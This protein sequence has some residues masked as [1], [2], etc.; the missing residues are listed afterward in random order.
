MPGSAMKRRILFLISSFAQG[1]AQRHLLELIRLLDPAAFEIAICTLNDVNHFGGDLPAGQPAY[2]LRSPVFWSPLAFA[3]LAGAIRSFRPD[4]LHCYL[5]DGNLWGRLASRLSRPG[6]VLTSVHLDEMSPLYQ[7]WERRLNRWSD[8]I[9]AHS[10]SIER[11]LVGDLAVPA[12][13]VSVIANGVDVDRFA[14]VTDASRR[15]ARDARGLGADAFVALMPARVAWQKNQDLVLEAMGAL[16]ARG[17][18]PAGFRLLLAGGI[19][20]QVL[21]RKV[22]GLIASHG[23]AQNVQRLGP[24]KDMPAVLHAADVVLLPSRT[25]ASPIAALEG[26]STAVPVVI[27]DTS[28]TDGVV[29]P[30]EHGWQV[31]ANDRP[32]L[33]RALEQV[34]AT[35][36]VER[37]RLGQ[38]GRAHV[39]ARFTNRRVAQDFT[40]VYD[41]IAPARAP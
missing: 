36:A 40:R 21:S 26:L 38:A 11:L 39:A 20:S 19:S 30:G 29:V 15:A 23:L 5:N 17:A 41:E 16:K 9:V 3:R 22:D 2:C 1:G 8:R 27:S 25:E 7:F 18:L 12:E 14:P 10:R 32:D 31:V 37:A 4:I 33:E 13:K 34:L 35:S 24:V 28:N 6:A